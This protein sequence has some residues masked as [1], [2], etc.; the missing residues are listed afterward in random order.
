MKFSTV[1][2]LLVQ[3]SR[4]WLTGIKYCYDHATL[5]KKKGRYTV[6]ICMGSNFWLKMHYR[7]ERNLCYEIWPQHNFNPWLLNFQFKSVQ[8][9]SCPARKTPNKGQ[10]KWIMVPKWIIKRTSF[11][12]MHPK[13]VLRLFYLGIMDGRM[14]AKGG[15]NRQVFD[16]IF[17]YFKKKSVIF[18]QFY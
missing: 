8:F 10:Q 3:L 7:Q 14:N 17:F 16:I 1:T 13:V 18:P 9:L 15:E 5:M 6:Q 2:K 11:I 4:L 12:Y